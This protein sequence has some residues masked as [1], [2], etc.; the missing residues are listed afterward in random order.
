MEDPTIA[1]KDNDFDDIGKKILLGP[2]R[3]VRFI[4]QLE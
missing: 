1:R 2:E 4:R 3:K